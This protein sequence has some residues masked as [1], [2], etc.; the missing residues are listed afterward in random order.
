MNSYN[1]ISLEKKPPTKKKSWRKKMNCS[2]LLM[3]FF[4]CFPI[5]VMSTK[6]WNHGIIFKKSNSSWTI[7]VFNLSYTHYKNVLTQFP[8]QGILAF[9]K[10]RQQKTD[11]QSQQFQKEYLMNTQ[12][13]L[14]GKKTSEEKRSRCSWSLLRSKAAPNTN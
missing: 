5:S 4:L 7:H 10:Q 1:S 14:N 2:T 11:T 6:Q 8:N 3:A 9:S 13:L 12:Q